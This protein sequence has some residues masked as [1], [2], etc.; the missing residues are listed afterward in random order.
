MDNKLMHDWSLTGVELDWTD[1]VARFLLMASP[2][3]SASITATGLTELVV[4]RYQEWGPSSSI[5]SSSGP[6]P[7][8]EENQRLEVLMQSGDR[9]VIVAKEIHM[10]ST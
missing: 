4:P 7:C 9:L 8:D 2:G 5:M 10:P 3:V 1:G 6:A